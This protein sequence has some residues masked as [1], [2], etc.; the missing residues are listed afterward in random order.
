MYNVYDMSQKYHN[1]LN[2]SLQ[3]IKTDS[4]RQNQTW[5]FF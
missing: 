5:Q 4:I 2:I 1:P 3:N